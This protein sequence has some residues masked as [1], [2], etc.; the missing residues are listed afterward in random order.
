M[1]DFFDDDLVKRKEAM[2]DLK[3]G[4][5]HENPSTKTEPGT[6]SDVPSRGVSDFN[7][8]SMT[9]HKIEIEDQVANA[10]K[11]LERLRQR[12]EDLEQQKESLENLRQ[13]QDRY[14]KGKRDVIERLSQNLVVLEKEELQAE[15]TLEL[16]HLTR[17][18]FKARLEEIQ[19]LNEEN[20]SEDIFREELSKALSLIDN[21]RDEYNKS[22]AKIEALS[23]EKG[24]GVD[25]QPML[26]N[27]GP[28]HEGEEKTFM[29]WLKVGFAVSFPV[30]V[31]LTILAVLYYLNSIGIL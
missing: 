7:L 19:D 24:S 21:T 13:R 18:K 5:G 9:R 23:R 12:Q 22:V 16:L 2:P 31:T 10:M 8:T 15:Q 26:L 29:S 27:E 11:E 14:A 6:S 20:W 28:D 17:Q 30:I 1:T 25:H 3:M 4:P